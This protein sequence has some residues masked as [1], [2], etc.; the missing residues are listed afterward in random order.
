MR[1]DMTAALL[2]VPGGQVEMDKIERENRP[3]T[4]AVTLILLIAST[5]LGLLGSLSL[6][7]AFTGAIVTSL[8][9]Y[10]F[11]AL[12]FWTSKQQGWERKFALP[13]AFFGIVVSGISLYQEITRLF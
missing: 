5:V 3:R 12:L 8:N 9:T 13:L 10:V 6:I 7:L 2:D 4:I 11:P 1:R